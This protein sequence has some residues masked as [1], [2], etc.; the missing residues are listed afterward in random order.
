MRIERKSGSTT[1]RL[2]QSGF[3]EGAEWNKEYEGVNSSWKMSLAILGFILKTISA[4][5]ERRR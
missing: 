1:V 5:Q 4:E 3:R 2:I